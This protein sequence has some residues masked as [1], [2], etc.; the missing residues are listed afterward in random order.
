[1]ANEKLNEYFD[2]AFSSFDEFKD[3]I[4]RIGNLIK[5]FYREEDRIRK[6]FIAKQLRE[7]RPE[8]REI[9]SLL[10]FINYDL[11]PEIKKA[12]KNPPEQESE[13][14]R[15]R[16]QKDKTNRIVATILSNLM[17]SS[18]SNA[19]AALKEAERYPDLSE[20]GREIPMELSGL[21]NLIYKKFAD[22][23]GILGK[24][25]GLAEKAAFYVFEAKKGLDLI[26][27]A[28]ISGMTPQNVVTVL[29]YTKGILMNLLKLVQ[30]VALKENLAEM[31]TSREELMKIK[32][33]L[34]TYWNSIIDMAKSRMEAVSAKDITGKTKKQ[35]LIYRKD[36]EKQLRLS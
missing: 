29:N 14:E 12:E 26:D 7:M 22:I 15:F 18:F 6:S 31:S 4:L 19:S 3:N 8:F 23:R 25:P 35:M 24:K 28:K 32:N 33:T 27:D 16:I 13:K 10:G 17:A 21:R 5:Q 20:E 9:L 34:T 11:L 2:I 30:D 36:F 1:M